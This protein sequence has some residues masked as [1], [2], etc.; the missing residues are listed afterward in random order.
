[1]EVI[2]NT[3]NNSFVFLYVIV[4]TVLLECKMEKQNSHCECGQ[5]MKQKKRLVFHVR[6]R[7][8]FLSITTTVSPLANLFDVPTILQG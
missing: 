8:G 4:L 3:G 1:M 7:C 6:I 2:Y 5:P